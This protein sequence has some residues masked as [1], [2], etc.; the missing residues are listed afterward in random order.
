MDLGLEITALTLLSTVM[1]LGGILL[2]LLSGPTLTIIGILLIILSAVVFLA[3]VADIIGHWQR[4]TR[5]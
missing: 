1:F 5:G 4:I 3:D 2:I